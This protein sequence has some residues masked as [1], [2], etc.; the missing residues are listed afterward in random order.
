MSIEGHGHFFTTYFSDFVCLSFTRPRYQVSVY[1]TL[2]YNIYGRD[3]HL[4]NV[5][6]TI[7]IIFVPFSKEARHEI[8]LRSAKGF[9]GR[10]C[11]N[12]VDND[13]DDDGHRITGIL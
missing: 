3:G 2:V 4:G 1:M 5:T 9:Q 7:Y 11:L 12:I 13:N 6:W 10:K 8:W